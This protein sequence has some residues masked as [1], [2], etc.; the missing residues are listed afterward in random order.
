MKFFRLVVLLMITVSLVLIAAQ[1]K[2]KPKLPKIEQKVVQVPGNKAWTDTGLA[3]R[4]QDVVTVTATGKVCFSAGI[5]PSCVDPDG[6]DRETYQNNYPNDYQE[7]FDPHPQ[8][9][10]AALIGGV[11]QDIFFVG[12]STF[13]EGDL[14]L[15]EGDFCTIQVQRDLWCGKCSVYISRERN[16]T[17][18]MKRREFLQFGDITLVF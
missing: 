7:C 9:N 3:L 17:R 8:W 2:D 5:P 18:K 13:H 16:L 10:H 6:W 1:E 4:P 14:C 12:K 15:V 11:N